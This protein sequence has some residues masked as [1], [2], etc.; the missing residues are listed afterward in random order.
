MVVSDCAVYTYNEVTQKQKPGP[1]NA[2]SVIVGGPLLVKQESNF[3]KV[4]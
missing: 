2:A 1:G 3:K 4:N